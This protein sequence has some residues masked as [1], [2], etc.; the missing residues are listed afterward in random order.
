MERNSADNLDR[1]PKPGL[2]RI[3]RFIEIGICVLVTP[4]RNVPDPA[5]AGEAFATRST[6]GHTELNLAGVDRAIGR[7]KY[8]GQAFRERNRVH[9]RLAAPRVR[10]ADQE[11]VSVLEVLLPRLDPEFRVDL[12]ESS[13]KCFCLRL[14]NIAAGQNMTTGILDF[15]E[16]GIDKCQPPYARPNEHVGERDPM[17][18]HPTIAIFC[19]ASAALSCGFLEKN[20]LTPA[21][22]GAIGLG[23]RLTTGASFGNETLPGVLLQDSSLLPLIYVN[24]PHLPN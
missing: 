4:W 10:T 14:P 19:C 23:S 11:A 21:F 5:E 3:S 22:H 13:G 20:T 6:T 17:L 24:P 18:P 7:H 9:H 16:L 1:P 15:Q 12:Q 8:P 2:G